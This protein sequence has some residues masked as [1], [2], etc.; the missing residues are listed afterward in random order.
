V[1]EGKGRE[2][3]SRPLLVFVLWWLFD[4]T[5]KGKENIQPALLVAVAVLLWCMVMWQVPHAA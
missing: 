1:G 4:A 2:K 5:S 3:L